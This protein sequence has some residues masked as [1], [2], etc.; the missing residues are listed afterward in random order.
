MGSVLD[1]LARAE[2]SSDLRHYDTP[3]AVDVLKAAGIAAMHAPIHIA[4][5][6]L[7]YLNDPGEIAACKAIFTRWA[8]ASMVRR[9]PESP[10]SAGFRQLDPQHASRVGS[11]TLQAWIDDTCKA[12]AGQKY[13]IIEGTPALSTKICG[14][15]KGLGTNPI[16]NGP[17]SDVV[18]DVMERADDAISSVRGSVEDKLRG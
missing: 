8:Y 6:R 2:T 18:R 17:L 11:Q 9:R 3:C 1:K 7:K 10:M 15:C 13:R 14:T 16:K 5:F 12:C 4:L